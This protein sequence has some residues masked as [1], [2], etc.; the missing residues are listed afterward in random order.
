MLKPGSTA[1]LDAIFA[2]KDEKGIFQVLRIIQDFL[3][4]QDR[5]PIVQ[6]GAKV[7]VETGIKIEELV[8]NVEGFA[9]SGCVHPRVSLPE[10]V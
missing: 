10:T 1:I 7:K 2:S 9:D 4:S 6:P 8:G 3:A 5:A